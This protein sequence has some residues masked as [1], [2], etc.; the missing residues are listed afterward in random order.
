MHP[1][2]SQTLTDPPHA[3]APVNVAAPHGGVHVAKHGGKYGGATGVAE[4]EAADR[5][6]LPTEFTAIILKKYAVPLLRPVT[7]AVVPVEVPSPNSV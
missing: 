5:A 1:G 3:V 2:T 7:V 6:L 4:V